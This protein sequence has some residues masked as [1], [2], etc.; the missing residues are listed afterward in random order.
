MANEG[1]KADNAVYSAGIK[2]PGVL[3]DELQTSDTYDLNVPIR[4]YR[5]LVDFGAELGLASFKEVSATLELEIQNDWYREGGFSRL[6]SRPIPTAPNMQP[7]SIDLKKGV[8]QNGYNMYNF[9]TGYYS[10]ANTKVIQ[11]CKIILYHTDGTPSAQ[12]N[13]VNAWPSKYSFDGSFDA[14]SANVLMETITFQN[15]GVYRVEPTG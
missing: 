8:F 2:L 1:L 7:S 10:G 6:V 13:V 15:E 4:G 12:W 3:G 9:L 14:T 5:F 11:E